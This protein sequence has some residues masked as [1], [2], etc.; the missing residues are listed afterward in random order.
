MRSNEEPPKG[1]YSARAGTQLLLRSTQNS[2]TNS[3]PNSRDRG[4]K[5]I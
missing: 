2:P 3:W 5:S 4:A 1:R